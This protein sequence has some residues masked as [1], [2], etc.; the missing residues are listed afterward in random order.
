MLKRCAHALCLAIVIFALWS[1]PV[2]AADDAKAW[3][4]DVWN[5]T[6]SP[7]CPGRTLL[8]CPSGQAAE[9]RTGSPTRRRRAAAARTSKRSST[10]SSAT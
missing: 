9:L 3:H 10:S 6:M 2:H 4:Y 5:T 8:D 7:F 1:L